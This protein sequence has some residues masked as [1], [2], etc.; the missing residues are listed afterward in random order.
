MS[1]TN[2]E[3]VITAAD[4]TDLDGLVQRL[5]AKGLTG[6]AALSSIGIITG[7]A[8][9]DALDALRGEPGVASVELGG[10]IQLPPPD[11]EVQ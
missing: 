9:P 4:D 1:P 5:A 3:V 6:G 8:A 2:H 7:N 10:E 11:S